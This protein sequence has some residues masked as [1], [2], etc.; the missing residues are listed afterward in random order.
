M[1]IRKVATIL[2]LAIAACSPPPSPGN[3]STSTTAAT[4]PSTTV[5]TTTAP[6]SNCPDGESLVEGGRV[7][8][9]AQPS[10]DAES[11][12]TI[13]WDAQAGCEQFTIEL[14]TDQGAPATTPPS[15]T[16][17]LL[18]EISVLRVHLAVDGTALTDQLVE[19]GLVS[20]YFV[21]RKVDRSLF[22]DF[23]LTGPAVARASLASGPAAVV[24]ELEP[25]GTAYSGASAIG[26]LVVL[27]SPQ[28]GPNPV[29]VVIEGYGRQFE[30][31]VVYLFRQDG[32]VLLQDVTNSTD[33]SETWGS[34]TT[35]ADPGVSGQMQLFVGQ[36]SAEDGS[37]R[38][39]LV[40]LEL[41]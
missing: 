1:D 38:G 2:S 11:I 22:V 7:L 25:G 14:V 6:A 37:E 32:L 23:H 16:V 8:D 39:V 20:R 41:P 9:V 5:A 19:T 24:I 18:R 30:A 3:S 40:D 29:P 21:V 28:A 31:T 27:T 33:Y 4:I 35:T 13:T 15:V 34:F 36:F 17:E 26:D 10:T 12:G